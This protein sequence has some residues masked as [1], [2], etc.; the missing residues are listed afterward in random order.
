MK[1]ISSIYL[2]LFIST[3]AFGQNWNNKGTI[4]VTFRVRVEPYLP[5]DE[6]MTIAIWKNGAVEEGGSSV[7]DQRTHRRFYVPLEK[8]SP[9][10]WEVTVDLDT[11]AFEN[12][13]ASSMFMYDYMINYEGKKNSK[14]EG[15]N[16]Q[17]PLIVVICG[18][19][20]RTVRFGNMLMAYLDG[21]LTGMWEKPQLF[22]LTHLRI[23]NF[24]Q[25][26]QKHS[27][28]LILL[29]IF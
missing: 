5:L 9:K 20:P 3:F 14:A 10:D 17:V 29:A 25:L 23:L 22:R 27:K 13:W 19:F 12:G 24:Q 6:I 16:H 7:Y 15:I 11:A 18:D 2:I 26:T 4:P 1:F 8:I 21:A 28:L